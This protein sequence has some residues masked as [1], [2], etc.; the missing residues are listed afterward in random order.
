MIRDSRESVEELGHDEDNRY[1]ALAVKNEMLLYGIRWV[2]G[3]WNI[4]S[5]PKS[6]P[7]MVEKAAQRAT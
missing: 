3:H 5:Y 4:Y 2:E 6:R 1:N 7:P